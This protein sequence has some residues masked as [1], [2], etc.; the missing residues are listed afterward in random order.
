MCVSNAQVPENV[1]NSADNALKTTTLLRPVEE[2]GGQT[3]GGQED[4][5][6]KQYVFSYPSN[7]FVLG[8]E[9]PKD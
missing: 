9:C 8:S 1:V 3:Q 7:A 2:P 5:L 6:S 4:A